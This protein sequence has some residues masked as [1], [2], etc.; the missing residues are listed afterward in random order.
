[1][2]EEEEMD[3]W[4][5]MIKKIGWRKNNLATS[6]PWS[7]TWSIVDIG[8]LDGTEPSLAGCP[9]PR[10][11]MT[12]PVG[13]LIDSIGVCLQVSWRPDRGSIG[14]TGPSDRSL[15]SD[16]WTWGRAKDRGDQHVS[17]QQTPSYR[18]EASFIW[19]YSHTFRIIDTFLESESVKV[20]NKE[21]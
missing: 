7:I 17:V 14:R 9:P 20:I 10:G 2:I 5:R 12:S 4:R 15:W 21:A 18:P 19:T 11:Q 13:R 3:G 8:A 16:Q 1:M 6:G